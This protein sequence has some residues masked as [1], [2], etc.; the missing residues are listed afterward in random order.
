MSEE[1]LTV[2][3]LCEWLKV[4]RIT[5]ERWRK[6]DMPFIKVGKIVRFDRAKVN[7]WLNAQNGGEL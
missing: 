5:V 4:T 1:L 3:E 6:K 2:N 7:E